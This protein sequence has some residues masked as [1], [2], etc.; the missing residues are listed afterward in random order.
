M[1]KE[2]IR[3]WVEEEI[4]ELAKHLLIVGESFSD[5]AICRELGLDYTTSKNC[6]QCKTEFKYITARH[7]GGGASDRFHWLKKIKG[8]RPELQFVDYDDFQKHISRIKARDL[9]K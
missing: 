5:C 9:L 4:L 3:F 2:F 8:K 6:P 1:P 7:S